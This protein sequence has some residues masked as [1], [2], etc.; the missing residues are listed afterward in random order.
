MGEGFGRWFAISCRHLRGRFLDEVGPDRADALGPTVVE[1]LASLRAV[2][3]T[4]TVIT[5]GWRETG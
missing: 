5:P 3:D 2:P 1:L 4:G